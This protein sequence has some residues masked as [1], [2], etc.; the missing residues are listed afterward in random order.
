[1]NHRLILT[2]LIV[3]LCFVGLS[4]KGYAQL[5]G[6]TGYA[7]G[8][9]TA[10][11]VKQI[12]TG[13]LADVKSNT[14]YT[15]QTIQNVGSVSKTFIGIALLKAQEQGL[16]SLD[17]DINQYLDFTLNTPLVSSEQKNT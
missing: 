4:P 5:K 13:G 11:E 1:M 14:A 16:L 7:S 6:F 15:E 2:C 10:T 17:Q 9:V 8:V 12:E 3:L